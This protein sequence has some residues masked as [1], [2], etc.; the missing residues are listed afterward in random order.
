MEDLFKGFAVGAMAV[1]GGCIVL[2][3]VIVFR[4]KWDEV[5]AKR[6]EKKQKEEEK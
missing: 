5:K 6:A 1:F 3:I 2:V 4:D